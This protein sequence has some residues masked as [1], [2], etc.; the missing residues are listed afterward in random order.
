MKD[1]A[2]DKAYLL[3]AV[4]PKAP[5]TLNSNEILQKIAPAIGGR[6]GGKADMAQAGGTNPAGLETALE[7]ART[8]VDSLI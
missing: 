8:I 6:G 1:P 5:K 2:G 3:V 7:Q 4:G